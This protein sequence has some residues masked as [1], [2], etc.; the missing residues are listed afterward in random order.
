MSTENVEIVVLV[1]PQFEAGPE[2]VGKGGIVKN[3]QVHINI[4]S[5]FKRICR[6]NDLVLIGLINSPIKGAK[7]NIEYLSYLTRDGEIENISDRD[8]AQI[9]NKAYTN[10]GG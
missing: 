9:V 5:N 2:D 4:L 8:I 6:L 7:G 3:Q 10:L 1:K